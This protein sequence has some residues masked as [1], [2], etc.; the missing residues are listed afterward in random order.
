MWLPDAKVAPNKLQA[1]L[2]CLESA[3]MSLPPSESD[4]LSLPQNLAR[5]YINGGDKSEFKRHKMFIPESNQPQTFNDSQGHWL[6][7]ENVIGSPCKL[8]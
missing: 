8:W 3:R 6:Q 7:P 2:G 1:M 4:H 5:D